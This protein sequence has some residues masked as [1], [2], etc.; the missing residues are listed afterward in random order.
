MPTDTTKPFQPSS[1]ADM[2]KIRD[3]A[4]EALKS[5]RIQETE[6]MIRSQ[7]ISVVELTQELLI[8]QA[9]LEMQAEELREANQRLELARERFRRFFQ[10]LPQPALTIDP[11]SA[12]I[13]ETNDM[14]RALF[15]TESVS[16]AQQSLFRRLG[17]GRSAQDLLA[18]A[19]GEAFARGR[20]RLW[21]VSLATR[22]GDIIRCRIDFERV[23]DELRGAS[24]LLAVISDET[25]SRARMD[26]LAQE[27]RLAGAISG[28]LVV[29]GNP[30]LSLE[31][32]LAQAPDI[33]TRGLRLVDD[34][35]VRLLYEG[36]EFVSADWKPLSNS[37]QVPVQVGSDTA[38]WIHF[39]QARSS[40]EEGESD[41]AKGAVPSQQAGEVHRAFSELLARIIENKRLSRELRR[42][43]R[44]AAIGQIAGG[45]AHDFNNLL[46]V[47]LG[48]AEE[49]ATSGVIASEQRQLAQ[50]IVSASLKAA[51]LTHHLL[52]YAGNQPLDPQVLRPGNLLAQVQ[53]KLRRA[54]REEIDLQI[55]LAND[56][57]DIEVDPTQFALALSNLIHNAQEAIAQAGQIVISAGNMRQSVNNP[58]SRS[59]EHF[60]C[61]YL[62]V[63]DDGAGMMPEVLARSLEPF[64]TTKGRGKGSGLGLSMVSGFVQQSGGTLDIRSVPGEGTR[65]RLYFPARPA[66]GV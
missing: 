23:D 13:L 57:S 20:A 38:G 41:E 66:L 50:G 25:E 62:E 14:A 12:A 39:G 18:A 7:N 33:M 11:V 15:R 43:D 60:D 6:E 40:S 27:S 44:L 4:I 55:V 24:V 61:V 59:L 9:E 10:S 65:V 3:L 31:E 35:G 17:H 28:L 30:A 36:Y 2:R 8:Y 52:A 5:G 47:I 16:G 48:E 51:E 26:Q 49:L 58:E 29:A 53:P 64:F 19:V 32:V 54:V 42:S 21:E 34:G 63:R 45:I 1:E 46:T 37:F 56:V 22:A